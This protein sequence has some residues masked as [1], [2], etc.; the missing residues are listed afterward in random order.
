MGYAKQTRLAAA[1]TVLLMAALISAPSLAAETNGANQTNQSNQK[2]N[3]SHKGEAQDLIT[4]ATQEV[5]TMEADPQLKQ[6]MGKAKGVFLV[7]EFGRGALIVG[8]RGGAGLVLAKN[9]GQW[10]DPAFYDFGAIRLGTQA[11]GSGGKIAFLLMTDNAVD[12]FKSGNK[13][14]LNAEAGLTI[15]N[16]SHNG[17][18]SWGKGDIVMWSDN[19]GLYGG[20]SVSV[21]DLN[22]AD[23]NNQAYYGRR[24]QPDQ[25]LDGQ[26]NTPD[27][28]Q[29][30]Q[31]LAG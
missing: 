25:I 4:K 15:V 23:N 17:Q 3:T 20:A 2:V 27:A 7:P 14:S 26:V 8:G 18:A 13:I 9:N 5:R 16:F 19:S 10:S 1:T 11:G 29:L 28:G 31:A 6:L 24:M 30:K 22:W 21:T 12:A